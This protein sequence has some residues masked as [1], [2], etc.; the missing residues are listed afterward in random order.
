MATLL[1]DT[2]KLISRFENCNNSIQISLKFF[3]NDPIDKPSSVK[4][5]NLWIYIYAS[6][7]FDVWQLQ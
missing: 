2:F 7:W 1:D 6:L 3:P 5:S 4:I